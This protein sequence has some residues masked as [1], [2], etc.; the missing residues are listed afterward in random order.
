[1]GRHVLDHIEPGDFGEIHLLSRRP[2]S[3]PETLTDRARTLLGDL[4]DP[5]TYRAA[6]GERTIVIHLAATVGNAP[7][8]RHQETNVEGTRALL[9]ASEDAGIRR[10]LLVSTIAVTFDDISGY[11]YALS[12]RAAEDLVRKSRLD[13]VIAR[14]TIVLG[15]GSPIWDRFRSLAAGPLLLVLGSGR[16]RIQPVWV[17]D[18]A[19]ALLRLAVEPGAAGRTLELG[20]PEALTVEDFL[21]RVRGAMGKGAGPALHI[22]LRPVL[23]PLRLVEKTTPL[24]LPVSAGQFSSFVYDGVAQRDELAWPPDVERTDV[25]AMLER[26]S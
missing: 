6:L 19:I 1:M 16:T 4:S 21:R 7:P 12:K 22:P 17:D 10:F 8:D 20:G 14:P 5:G 2:P 25:T 26:L 18:L 15:L 3:L 23:A 24:R 9:A 13:H 11:P